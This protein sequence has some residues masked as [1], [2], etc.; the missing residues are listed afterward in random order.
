MILFL[1][2]K[3]AKW[4]PHKLKYQYHYKDKKMQKLSVLLIIALLASESTP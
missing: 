3:F 2:N 1:M 4:Y